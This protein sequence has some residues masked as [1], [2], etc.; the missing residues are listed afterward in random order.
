MEISITKMCFA[1]QPNRLCHS[2]KVCCEF[3][4]LSFRRFFSP[5]ISASIL[6]AASRPPGFVCFTSCQQQK[7]HSCLVR[8]YQLAIDVLFTDKA[9][10]SHRYGVSLKLRGKR[11]MFLHRNLCPPRK[12]ETKFG[13]K[14]LKFP[15]ILIYRCL[16]RPSHSCVLQGCWHLHEL[17]I[18]SWQLRPVYIS[19]FRL[20]KQLDGLHNEG[21]AFLGF[22]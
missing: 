21:M 18:D 8:F 14:R 17:L 4:S 2:L 3:G 10:R 13:P 1:V 7:H 5:S 12:K 6:F 15:L 16:E 20:R 9:N 11:R 22:R 19:I